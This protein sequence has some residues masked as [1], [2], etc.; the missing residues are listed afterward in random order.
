MVSVY[1]IKRNPLRLV[2]A[3]LQPGNMFSQSGLINDSR[4][5]AKS[6]K[7]FLTRPTREMI[8]TAVSSKTVLE[9][10]RFLLFSLRTE[11][12]KMCV[13]NRTHEE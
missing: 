10:K 6:K 1:L 12:S 8:L 11:Q 3:R 4:L 13:T 7:R 2:V 9:K 5:K